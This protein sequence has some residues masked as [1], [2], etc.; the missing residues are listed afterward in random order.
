MKRKKDNIFLTFRS[1]DSNP[2]FEFSLLKLMI[3]EPFSNILIGYL[4]VNGCK[5]IMF[6]LLMNQI[7]LGLPCLNNLK[8]QRKIPKNDYCH[9]PGW[10]LRTKLLDNIWF[11]FWQLT[12]QLVC[13]RGDSLSTAGSRWS[14][15]DSF[16]ME[17]GTG[18]GG[19]A[20]YAPH[21]PARPSD[22]KT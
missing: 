17:Q 18:G 2:R 8:T 20:D 22:F 6:I 19:G 21:I 16:D 4:N 3:F 12:S 5:K 10:N 15:F 14:L 9:C 7:G 13:N 1:R 11:F